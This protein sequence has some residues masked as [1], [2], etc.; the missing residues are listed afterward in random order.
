[1]LG[2]ERAEREKA[3]ARS[4]RGRE[5]PPCPPLPPSRRIPREQ[6]P[7]ASRRSDGR[8][9]RWRQ[10]EREKGRGVAEPT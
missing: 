1:M 4:K 2:R 5:R 8:E 9:G 10:A 6:A 7:A 3:A